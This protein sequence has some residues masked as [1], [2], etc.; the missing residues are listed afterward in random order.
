[1]EIEK[2]LDEVNTHQLKEPHLVQ[3]F[4]RFATYNGSSPYKTPGIMSL[5]QHL[6]SHYGTYFPEGGMVEIS[7]SLSKTARGSFSYGKEGGTN[8]NS[9]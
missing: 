7:Q 6:E 2:S 8:F 3:F 1:M 4:N 5:V 9:K